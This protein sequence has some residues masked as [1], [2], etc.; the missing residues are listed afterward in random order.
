MVASSAKVHSGTSSVDQS[1]TGS[2]RET[3]SV[4]IRTMTSASIN[5]KTELAIIVMLQLN[6]GDTI[7]NCKVDSSYSNYLDP[8]TY[9]PF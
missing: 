5:P 3:T 1:N 9:L 7:V 6:I 8:F 4:S 2:Q